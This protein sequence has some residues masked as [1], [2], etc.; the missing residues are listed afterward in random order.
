[1]Y[2]P[3]FPQH[4]FPELHTL[5]ISAA[6]LI[7]VTEFLQILG[8]TTLAQLD[9][10]VFLTPTATLLGCFFLTVHDHCSRRLLKHLTVGPNV[11]FSLEDPM[12]DR[13]AAVS[14][15]RP[16]LAFSKMETLSIDVYVS[17]EEIDNTFL[18]EVALAFPHLREFTLGSIFPWGP[19]TKANLRCLIPFARHCK[20][21]YFLGFTLD[22]TVIDN[23]TEEIDGFV[24]GIT[25]GRS[26]ITHDVYGVA[27]FLWSVFPK[28][29]TIQALK[30]RDEGDLEAVEYYQRWEQVMSLIKV[31]AQTRNSKREVF[32]T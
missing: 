26:K 10:R 13:T 21:L 14:Q 25:V 28:L 18:G 12:D 19:S 32:E 20:Q 30:A 1:M 2:S 8:S 5:D 24:T 11:Y 29:E 31:H 9:V 3:V 16:L 27:S 22:A 6:N 7:Q 23:S 17:F 15:F 4:P